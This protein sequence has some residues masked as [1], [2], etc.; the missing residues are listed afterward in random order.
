MLQLRHCHIEITPQL[1]LQAA[2]NLPLVLQRLR[3][4]D[5]QLE[6]EQTDRHERLRGT[7]LAD[8]FLPAGPLPCPA[9]SAALILVT[10]K[11]SR[12]SP[13]FTS[14]KLATP[15]PHSNPVRTSLASS[16]NRFKE[17]SFDAQITAPSRSTRT[18]ASRFRMPSTT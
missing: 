2:Q 18:C 16:L 14:L 15:A 5:V 17:L 8:Y 4:R 1:I 13:T 7:A 3:V 6:G 12:I 10:L 9:A 11:H